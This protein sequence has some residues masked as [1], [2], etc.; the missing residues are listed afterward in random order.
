MENSGGTFDVMVM[1]CCCC[2]GRMYVDVHGGLTATYEGFAVGCDL[3]RSLF[4]TDHRP[5]YILPGVPAWAFGPSATSAP[6]VKFKV[7]GDSF[8]MLVIHM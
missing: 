3:I 8:I 6:I 7:P 4:R 1:R 5:F 2:L